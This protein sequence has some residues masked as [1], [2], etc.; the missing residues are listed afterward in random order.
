MHKN[1]F[2]KESDCNN[3]ITKETVI[4]GLG[5]CK[6]CARKGVRNPFFGK[7]H[8]IEL[9]T[10]ITKDKINR[11]LCK[12]K[13][14]PAYI[15]GRTLKQYYCLVCGRKINKNTWL[16]GTKK[17]IK[18]VKVKKKYY[19]KECNIRVTSNC[20]KYGTGLCQRCGNLGKRNPS[21]IDGRSPLTQAIRNATEYHNWRK[22]VFKRDNYTCQSCGQ[23]GG[24]L[25]AHHKNRFSVLL[26]SFLKQYD[27][28]SPI[29]DRETL[30]RL[31]M[32]W[33]PFWDTDNGQM[34]CIDCHNL[35]K[36]GARLI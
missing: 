14:N 11:G 25:E 7:R 4:N 5:R 22:S 20:I 33:K 3:I 24:K 35:T 16:R 12:G 10:K 31:A 6:S 29:E 21:F 34:L 9:Q 17:C 2:C 1:Y 8:S 23:V 27:Q 32:K 15:D 26:K 18:C 30:V 19:C 28:F 36:V 13:N